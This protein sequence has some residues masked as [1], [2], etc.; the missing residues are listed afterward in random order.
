MLWCR[1]VAVMFFALA[2]PPVVLGQ[3]PAERVWIGPGY[4]ANRL[5]D[6]RVVAGRIECIEAR[7]NFPLRTL[8]D[9]QRSV[10]PNALGAVIQVRLGAIAPTGESQPGALA[11]ILIGAG[12]EDVDY[13]LTAQIHHRPATDGGILVLVDESG[14]IVIRDNGAASNAGNGW[15]IGGKLRPN[16]APVLEPTSRSDELADIKPRGAIDLSVH[17]SSG[18]DGRSTIRGLASADGEVL[19]EVTL[20][21]LDD[22]QVSGMVALVSHLGTGGMGHWF[23]NWHIGTAIP[24][25]SGSVSIHPDRAFGPVWNAMYT[26]DDG[27]TLTLTAQFPPIESGRQQAELHIADGGRW[28][29]VAR[30]EID[31]DSRT[32]VFRVPEWDGSRRTRYRVAYEFTDLRGNKQDTYYEGVIRATPTD[33]EFVIGSL[34]CMKNYTGGLAWNHDGIWF[35]HNETAQAVAYHDPDFL[36][37]AGDQIYEGDIDPV[38]GRND[39][40]AIL[41]YLYKWSRFCWSFN[42]I[43]RDRP[44]ICIPDDHDVYHGNLWGAG[45]K[46]AQAR[47]GL[48]AQDSGGYKKSPRVINAVHRTQTSHL[49]PPRIDGPVGE[50]YSVYTTE[51][52]YAGISFAILA[53]RQFKSSASVMVPDGRVVNGW[54]QNLEF[55]PRDADVPDAKLLGDSQLAFLGEWSTDW[56]EGTWTKVCLSQTPFANVATI[57]A[58]AKS[59]SVLPGLKF[60]LPEEYPSEYKLAV[61]TDSGGWP[62]SGRDKAVR[63]LTRAGAVHLAG[64]QHLA[65][66]IEYGVDEFRDGGFCFTSPAIANTWPRRWWP[67][68]EGLN[69]EPN[70]ARYTGDFIDG[71]GNRMTVWGVANPVQSGHEPRNL[72]DRMPGYGIVRLRRTDGT[73]EFECWPRWEDPSEPGAKQFA[74]WPVTIQQSR[75]GTDR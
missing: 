39:D 71:F 36:F 52:T 35:P 41:D 58:S 22:R 34:N 73:I 31:P 33:E 42:E 37:F 4:W 12:A 5:Q 38:D 69:R 3:E 55:D 48:S 16:E 57:P 24:D 9:L 45:G 75:N 59:G 15:S 18:P 28:Q 65:T 62:Q 47:D 6:W 67:P 25:S 60:P 43:T 66:L 32:A 23:E 11:G 50:G 46:R 7:E 2:L 72:Y 54:F 61:D 70:S 74:G 14:R 20:E 51:L 44:T 30:A 68:M 56:P 64:D 17:I 19:D 10:R 49:P 53:D 63:L 8:F 1:H 26:V 13:R 27:G 40:V 21:G 29:G